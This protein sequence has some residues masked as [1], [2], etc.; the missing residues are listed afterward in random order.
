MYMVC[1]SCHYH[2]SY[3]GPYVARSGCE[4]AGRP[5]TALEY[6]ANQSRSRLLRM[7]AKARQR[8]KA[9]RENKPGDN[10]KAELSTQMCTT[11]RN[12][13]PSKSGM[14][15]KL[16]FK[17]EECRRQACQHIFPSEVHPSSEFERA[18]ERPHGEP[19]RHAVARHKRTAATIDRNMGHTAVV[20]ATYAGT[21]DPCSTTPHK[22]KYMP[23]NQTDTSSLTS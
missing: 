14:S 12:P 16:F 18:G 9:T 19:R 1:A 20:V 10:G 4:S 23:C 15:E 5:N 8:N 3:R 17:L 21:V 6:S 2:Y 13:P 11:L 7:P 22:D